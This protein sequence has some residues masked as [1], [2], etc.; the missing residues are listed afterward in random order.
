MLIKQPNGKYCDIDYQGRVKFL[1]YTEQDIIDMY[2]EKAKEYINNAEHYGKIIENIECGDSCRIERTIYDEHLELMGF[3][4]PYSELVKLV[5]RRPMNQSYASVDFAIYGMCP[6]CGGT[7]Q[8]GM[9]GKDD[10]CKNC[11]QVLKW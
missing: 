4:N 8:N 7:V 10:S 6:C 11:G 3:N 2:I 9:G 1:N 5:P